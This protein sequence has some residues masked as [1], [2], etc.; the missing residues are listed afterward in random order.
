MTHRGTVV[1]RVH[2]DLSN[3]PFD[4]LCRSGR[5]PVPHVVENLD[6]RRATTARF[7]RKSRSLYLVCGEVSAAVKREQNKDK[8]NTKIT[9]AESTDPRS[10]F[11]TN[12]STQWAAVTT[13]RSL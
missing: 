4:D 5:C 1:L 11:C 2:D 9:Y 12:P 7:K 8:Q 10:L 3:G 6:A 13:H